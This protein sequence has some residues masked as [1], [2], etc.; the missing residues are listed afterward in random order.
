MGTLLCQTATSSSGTL[1]AHMD[2]RWKQQRHQVGN[3]ERTAQPYSQIR[4]WRLA[5]HAGLQCDCWHRVPAEIKFAVSVLIPKH[6]ICALQ[7]IHTVVQW[8]S[9]FRPWWKHT[10]TSALST[11]SGVRW[12]PGLVNTVSHHKPQVEVVLA[13]CPLAMFENVPACLGHLSFDAATI[14]RQLPPIVCYLRGS[15]TDHTSRA[16]QAHSLGAAAQKH[17]L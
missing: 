15:K 4:E 12:G 16:E 2:S 11:S 8:Q 3:P 7:L 5:M 14:A 17:A 10:Y 1:L 13:A 6:A 9:L